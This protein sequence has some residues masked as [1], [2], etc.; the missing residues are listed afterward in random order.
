MNN[1]NFDVQ[2]HRGCRGLLPEN[3][4]E[5]FEKALKI[6]VTTLEMDVVVS[7][8]NR[9]IVSHEPYISKE[10]CDIPDSIPQNSDKLN[11]YKMDHG[12]I[13][14]F[15]CGTKF[16]PRFPEQKKIS[17]HKPTLTEVI[18]LAETFSEK[19]NTPPVH[20][21]IETK[22]IPETDN[23][24]HPEPNEFAELLIQTIKKHGLTDR[25]TL[26][27]FDIRT[28]QY[29]HEKY[30]EVEIALLIENVKPFEE[31]IADL[32]FKP[33]IYSPDF[34][35]LDAQDIES[36]HEQ[37]IRVIP[38]TVNEKDD[39]INL[40]DWGIDGIITDYPNRLTEVLTEIK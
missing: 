20:F 36:L 33:D 16:N 7:R 6:G 37:N 40:I 1:E 21:N 19:N 38:W 27:S 3:S 34:E 39:M 30:P 5:A 4:L 24:Y 22:C 23:I 31:N 17:T 18:E 25:F 13:R 10:I 9:L 35:L 32:G 8:D 26:Q 11:I 14:D 28:L 2:G 15:D 29:A 12:Q